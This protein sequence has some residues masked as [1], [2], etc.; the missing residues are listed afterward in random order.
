MLS[1]DEPSQT[2]LICKG[3]GKFVYSTIGSLST[4][5]ALQIDQFSETRTR[6]HSRALL[7]THSSRTRS[8]EVRPQARV[9]WSDF[10]RRQPA[11]ILIN[12]R[13]QVPPTAPS[14]SQQGKSSQ[15][16]CTLNKSLRFP[17]RMSISSRLLRL[18][19]PQV[20]S[21]S[22]SEGWTRSRH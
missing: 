2:G 15:G 13:L 21:P 6:L 16:L 4:D 10:S 14:L 18:A 20:R 11:P 7:T 9:T 8:L 22:I 5:R 17:S 12:F 1:Y 19:R 3:Y